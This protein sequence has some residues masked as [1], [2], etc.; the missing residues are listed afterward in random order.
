MTIRPTATGCFEALC[1]DCG[2]SVTGTT[3][4]AM[5]HTTADLGWHFDRL[6]LP[7]RHFCP[8]CCLK[9]TAG[10]DPTVDLVA[11]SA[12]VMPGGIVARGAD[13]PVLGAIVKTA[14]PPATIAEDLIAKG[15][16]ADLM[17]PKIPLPNLDA[18]EADLD[19]LDDFEAELAMICNP[20]QTGE[21]DD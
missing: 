11:F 9:L 4:R 16:P 1:D 12:S 18:I 6:S 17:K 13:D 3:V 21:A 14:Q 7:I 20:R 5:L 2:T 19:D 8:A 10:N 15:V